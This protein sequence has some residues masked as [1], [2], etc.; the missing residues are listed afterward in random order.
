MQR[1][2]SRRCMPIVH[3]SRRPRARHDK[4]PLGKSFSVNVAR[5]VVG[6]VFLI[7]HHRTLGETMQWD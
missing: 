1:P 2:I 7:R 6:S 5:A 3:L 4:P